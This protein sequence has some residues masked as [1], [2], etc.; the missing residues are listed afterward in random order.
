MKLVELL[1]GKH[2]RAGAGD[3]VSHGDPDVGEVTYARLHDAVTGYAGAL[4]ERGVPVGTRALVVADDSVATTAAILGLW[5]HGCVPVPVSPA[6]SD[7]ELRF[8]AADCEAGFAHFDFP[9]ASRR[10][11]GDH[12]NGLPRS[13][14]DEVRTVFGGAPDTKVYA[15]EAA[16][17]EADWAARQP[18]LIQYTSGS[19]GSPKGVLHAATGIEAVAASV[20][21]LAGLGPEDV[22]LSTAKVSFGYGFGNSVI[23]PLAAGARTVALRGGVDAHAVHSA[24]RRHRPTVLFSVPRMYVALLALTAA[25]GTDAIASLRLAVTAGEHCPAA[26]A[27]QVREKLGVP[28]INGLGATEA[29]HIVVATPPAAATAGATGRPVTGV[30]AT[31]RDKDGAPLPDGAEGVLHV[32][33]PCVALG[34]LN[35]TEATRRTFADGGAYT[36]D[37]VR[38]DEAGDFWYLCRADD[39][40]NMGGYK[41]APSEIEAVVREA[42]EVAECAVVAVSDEN[43][44]DQAVAYAVPAPGVD[45]SVVRKAILTLLRSRLA[46]FKRPARVEVIDVLPTTSTGKLARNRLR[47]SAG[48]A[49]GEGR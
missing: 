13:T 48:R 7:P 9:N 22:V 24:L 11:L 46:P 3:R 49:A 47:E 1:V 38:R 35:R 29:L 45:P 25:H 39:L 40:L 19:T 18:A 8:M 42:I 43:G 4:R 30:S 17:D 28:L 5:W 14:G 12:I 36:G 2:V 33:G 23:L 34:Y 31:V 27:E 26:L 21:S 6:L 44:L 41:V 32:A 16:A 10:E 15:P 37:I 20:G